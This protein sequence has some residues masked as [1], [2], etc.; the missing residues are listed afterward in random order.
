[1]IN[2]QKIRF[3]ITLNEFTR[4]QREGM[5]REPDTSELQ[6]FEDCVKTA[7]RVYFAATIGDA[8]TAESIINN[9]NKE[10]KQNPQITKYLELYLGWALLGLKQGTEALEAVMGEG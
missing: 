1:M 10:R 2:K 3:P 7:N 8:D 6:I 4:F 9:I 5:G